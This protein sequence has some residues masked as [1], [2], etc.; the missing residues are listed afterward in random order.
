MDETGEL[1][2]LVGSHVG[3]T[4]LRGRDCA[5]GEGGAVSRVLHA[6]QASVPSLT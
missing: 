4:R 5:V 6:D 3:T 2:R 1:L